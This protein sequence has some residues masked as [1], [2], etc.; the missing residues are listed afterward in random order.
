MGWGDRS[1]GMVAGEALALSLLCSALLPVPILGQECDPYGPRKDCGYNGIPEQFCRSKGCCYSE[2]PS[3][4]GASP[5]SLPACFYSNGGAS[6]FKWTGQYNVNKVS[7]DVKGTIVPDKTTLP[8][9]G[10]DLGP[11]TVTIGPYGK[12][13]MLLF[14]IVK[15]N[16]FMVPINVWQWE[17]SAKKGAELSCDLPISSSGNSEFAY[18][19]YR[20]QTRD[21]ILTS[22]GTRLIYKDQYL[23]FNIPVGADSTLYGL[24]ET[25]S[26]TGLPLRRTGWPYVLWNRD[27]PASLFDMNIY[28]S[29]PVLIEV[30]PDGSTH[31]FVMFNSNG[32]EVAITET[33]A[34]FRIV[35]GVIYMVVLG[36]PTPARFLD[37]LTATIGRP[38]MPPYWSLGLMQSKY[39]YGSVEFIDKVVKNYSAFNIP[40]ET[41]VTDSQYMD[42]DQDFTVSPTYQLTEFQAFIASLH[43]AGQRWV[44]ILDPVIHVA[45]GYSAYMQGQD[46]DIWIKDITGRPY[47]GQLWPGGVNFPDFMS[48]QG[49]SWWRQQLEAMYRQLPFD[50]LWLDMNEPSNYCTGDV[51]VDP[52]GVGPRND[53]VCELKCANGPDAFSDIFPQNRSSV[54]AGIFDPPFSINNA[55][56]QRP[57]SE[58][59]IAVTASH[60][61]GTLEYDVHNLFS[62]YEVNATFQVLQ[63]LPK[64]DGKRSRPFILTRSTWLGSGAK[65][66]HWTGDTASTWEDMK[67]SIPSILAN[68]LAGIAFTGADI[69]G[70]MDYPDE[71]LCARW[72]AI[73]AWYPYSRNH[74]AQGF[75]EFY[76]WDS[77]AEA[78]RQNFGW[79]YRALPYFVHS[80]LR[81]K[82]DRLPCC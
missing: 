34:Q 15:E 11:L 32:M 45:D 33:R 76:R 48:P 17:K 74:H 69:C 40:L 35:G 26:S 81:V 31:G 53:F 68:G 50:G 75:Q 30:R 43:A 73:G 1:F 39:G 52:G 22:Q 38:V 61:D 77:V 37:Q 16:R 10:D 41:F 29:H 4:I 28:G 18:T 63:D 71:T 46:M 9:L 57:L 82:P 27:S 60:Y 55:N 5:M 49:Q 65:A 51:C 13:D 8:E 25:T 67:L 70:F 19:V 56:G 20:T 80:L 6:T 72:A 66:A 42:K 12:R 36:G 64:A 79:R 23:E 3:F 54:P 44:P 78:A 21:P 62:Y 24:G 14:Q 7:L 58:K 2:A 59:T 47:V